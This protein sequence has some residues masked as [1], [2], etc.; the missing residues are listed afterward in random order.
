MSPLP[1]FGVVIYGKSVP[2]FLDRRYGLP[3]VDENPP[4]FL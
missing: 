2:V 4:T 1:P 3:K